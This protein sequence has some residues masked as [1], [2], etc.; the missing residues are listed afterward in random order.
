VDELV[1]VFDADGNQ[2]FLTDANGELI[3]DANGD[4]IPLLVPITVT[5]SMSVAG[6][7][8]S[9]R[10]FS[11]FRGRRQSCRLADPARAALISE[12]IDIGGQY[13]NNPF[14]VPQ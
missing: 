7:N 10:F 14:D 1:E 3:L 2:V 13:Y 5:P 6:A 12:W 9:P 4:P 8:A 11:L